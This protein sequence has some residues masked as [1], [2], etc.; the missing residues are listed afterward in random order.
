MLN[1]IDFKVGSVLYALNTF[2]VY[3]LAIPVSL[4]T[5]TLIVLFPVASLYVPR[6]FTVDKLSSLVPLIVIPVTLFSTF[7]VY[8]NVSLLNSGVNVP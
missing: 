8:S 4:V 5:V 2:I 7:T 1:A 3:C 6:P